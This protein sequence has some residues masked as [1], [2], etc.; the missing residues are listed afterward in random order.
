MILKIKTDYN[1]W[2]YVESS[3]FY[4][5][6]GDFG[7]FKVGCDEYIF[8][9]EINIKESSVVTWIQ[10]SNSPDN[11]NLQSIMTNCLCFLLNDS[12]KTVDRIM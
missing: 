4:I 11:K 3:S 7:N 6:K 12:G 10:F 1:S 8:R 5:T 9:P 2:K